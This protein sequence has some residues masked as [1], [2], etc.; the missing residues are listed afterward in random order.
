MHESEKWKWSHS[1]E[2]NPQRPHGL[3][4]TRLLCLWD[5]PG[6]N[7][8]VGCHCLLRYK[9]KGPYKHSSFNKYSKK[10]K[11][12]KL[13]LVFCVPFLALVIIWYVGQGDFPG[14]SV[15]K[16]PPANA[17]NARDTGWI[18]GLGRSP[19]RGNG[20]LTQVLWSGQSHGQRSLVGYSP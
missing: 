2:S 5:F 4:P 6:K 17:R 18:P 8:G 9:P 13:D 3:R 12:K 16:N 11:T 15:V 14:G 10:G 19:R 1:V 20:Q 7:T